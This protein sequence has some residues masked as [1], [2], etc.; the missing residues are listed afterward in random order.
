M[1]L[2]EAFDNCVLA[3]RRGRLSLLCYIISNRTND[4]IFDWFI[5]SVSS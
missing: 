4:I 5:C 2:G 3:D 1:E